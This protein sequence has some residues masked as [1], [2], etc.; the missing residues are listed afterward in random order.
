MG[1]LPLLKWFKS[2]GGRIKPLGADTTTLIGR[3]LVCGGYK[4]EASHNSTS[5]K[6]G[7]YVHSRK[8]LTF[9]SG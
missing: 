1:I 3:F 7:R 2:W 8:H 4:I 5:I 6:L 9:L